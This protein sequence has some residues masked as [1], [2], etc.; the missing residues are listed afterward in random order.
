MNEH[1]HYSPE[2]DDVERYAGDT[3]SAKLES[4]VKTKGI[5]EF[6][7]EMHDELQDTG[8]Y[9]RILN[10]IP[11]VEQVYGATS[12]MA[13]AFLDGAALGIDHTN[14]FMPH[15]MPLLDNQ[16]GSFMAKSLDIA[17]IQAPFDPAS[18]HGRFVRAIQKEGRDHFVEHAQVHRH[19]LDQVK[20]ARDYTGDA[21][22]ALYSGFGFTME[23]A[24]KAYQEDLAQI[25][26]E[27]GWLADIAKSALITHGSYDRV[28]NSEY[29]PLDWLDHAIQST[30]VNYRARN[31]NGD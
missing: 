26:I 8:S 13:D 18:F 23:R 25:T 14:R 12:C 24:T 30:I 3:I 19:I 11:D 5:N 27:S 28:Q 17:K 2:Y 15:L 7:L 16:I 4:I 20:R 6:L 21:Q 10:F 22:M 9:L 31:H 29:G 1:P